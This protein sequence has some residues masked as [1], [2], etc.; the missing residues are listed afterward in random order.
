M[1]EEPK[2]RR[3]PLPLVTKEADLLP[4]ALKAAARAGDPDPE[5]VQHVSGT[6][7]K[8]TTLTGSI[9][10]SDD[11]CYM[12]AI[13]GSFSGRRPFPH[14]PEWDHRRGEIEH[15]PVKVLVVEISSGRIVDSGGGRQWPDLAQVGP[16]VTD[17]RRSP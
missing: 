7:Q 17:R 2:P 12:I 9:V 4:L 8:L 16:V 14:G 13:R 15:W 3:E 11:P 6:R 1:A 10:H 5:L